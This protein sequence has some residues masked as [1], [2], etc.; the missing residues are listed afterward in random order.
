MLEPKL[1]GVY[2]DFI[3]INLQTHTSSQCCLYLEWLLNLLKLYR[4]VII[5]H[6]LNSRIL[7]YLHKWIP[8]TINNV[9]YYY[10][11]IIIA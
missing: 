1:I 6:V 7:Q 10:Y 4:I 9:S 5:I 8:N 3:C 2:P 11:F